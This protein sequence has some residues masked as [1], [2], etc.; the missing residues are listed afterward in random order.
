MNKFQ[1]A[2]IVIL[3]VSICVAFTKKVYLSNRHTQRTRNIGTV[4]DAIQLVG[5]KP[6]Q[7]YY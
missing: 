7:S 3:L 2:I 5:G 6:V 1:D 4:D